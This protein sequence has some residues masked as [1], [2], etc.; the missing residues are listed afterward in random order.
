MTPIETLY[1]DDNLLTG[2]VPDLLYSLTDLANL[3]LSNNTGLSGTISTAIG[4]LSKLMRLR[5]ENTGMGGPIPE[6]IYNLTELRSLELGQG[7]FSGPLSESISQLT[8]LD[9]VR[10][11][12]NT[13]TGTI[14]DGFESLPFL[15]KKHPTLG[16]SQY[17]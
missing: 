17:L 9:L 14:P 7:S 10:L 15:G 11:S 16:K 13:F 6:E 5:I 1:L 12:N 2:F 4:G 8:N 3:R